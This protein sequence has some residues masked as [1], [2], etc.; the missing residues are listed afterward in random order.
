MLIRKL[1]EKLFDS[2]YHGAKCYYLEC[3]YAEF[4]GTFGKLLLSKN[5]FFF[6]AVHFFQ[7]FNNQTSKRLDIL[8]RKHL[9]NS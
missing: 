7:A 3:R 1:Q 5:F 9:E 6:K 8:E 2:E 4:H